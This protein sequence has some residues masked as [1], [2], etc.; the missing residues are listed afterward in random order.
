[1]IKTSL[2]LVAITMIIC[3]SHEYKQIHFVTG[4]FVLHKSPAPPHPTP[5]PITSMSNQTIYIQ[6]ATDQFYDVLV[7][8]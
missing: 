2:N 7:S 6:E 5:S 3:S 4:Y 1:M 8:K